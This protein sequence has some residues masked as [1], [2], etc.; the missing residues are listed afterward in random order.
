MSR[1]LPSLPVAGASFA[2]LALLAACSSRGPAERG[3]FSPDFYDNPSRILI[4]SPLAGVMEI[5]SAGTREDAIVYQ[6]PVSLGE[7]WATL[8]RAYHEL[9][10]EGAGVVDEARRIFGYPNG[11]FPRRIAERRLSSF[12]NCGQSPGGANANVYRVTGSVMVQARA[13]E[14]GSAELEILVD[15]SAT[16]REV[17]GRTVRCNSNGQLEQL[18]ANTA[19][20]WALRE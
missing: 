9:G 10:F 18:L 8:P 11:A 13:G 3:E 16:P 5:E 12:L 7:V 20:V 15:A 17:S 4:Q 2:V 1:S 6:V 14:D 19:T